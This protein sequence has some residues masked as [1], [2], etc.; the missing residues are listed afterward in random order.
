[1]HSDYGAGEGSFYRAA[2]TSV[3]A[4]PYWTKDSE[5]VHQSASTRSMP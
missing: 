4:K 2:V 3:G 5:S 1:M